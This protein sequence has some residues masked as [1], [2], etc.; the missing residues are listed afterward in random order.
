VVANTCQV[1]TVT[2]TNKKRVIVQYSECYS[3]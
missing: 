1:C 2:L 3:V